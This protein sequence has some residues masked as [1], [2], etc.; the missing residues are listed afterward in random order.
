VS[1]FNDSTERAMLAEYKCNT[2]SAR[3]TTMQR[4]R[5]TCGEDDEATGYAMPCH[6]CDALVNDDYGRAPWPWNAQ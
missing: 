1:P 3:R 2:M 6:V 5:K 4:Q